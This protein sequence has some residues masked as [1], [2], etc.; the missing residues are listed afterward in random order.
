MIQFDLFSL[1]FVTMCILSVVSASGR[2][3]KRESG[4]QE[5]VRV[6]EYHLGVN[7]A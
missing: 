2:C 6:I 7:V 1:V 3:H 4:A 5:S